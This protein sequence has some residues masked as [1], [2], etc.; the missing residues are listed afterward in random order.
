MHQSCSDV[1]KDTYL[2]G[3]EPMYGI[4]KIYQQSRTSLLITMLATKFPNPTHV[5]CL[6]RRSRFSGFQSIHSKMSPPASMSRVPKCVEYTSRLTDILSTQF[7]PNSH[8]LA[9]PPPSLRRNMNGFGPPNQFPGSSS[10]MEVA[11]GSWSN[12]KMLV[13]C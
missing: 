12:T 2:Y 6:L 9:L 8:S 10:G 7:L 3:Y 4:P 1:C 11:P 13:V 5:V